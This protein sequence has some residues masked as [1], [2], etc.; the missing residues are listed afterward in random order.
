MSTHS[1][2]TNEDSGVNMT[3]TSQSVSCQSN[4]IDISNL[5]IVVL[6]EEKTRSSFMLDTNNLEV[7][8]AVSKSPEHI[9]IIKVHSNAYL[10]VFCFGLSF[11]FNRIY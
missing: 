11:F 1:V 9:N 10:M 2:S 7:I 5:E 4:I 3:E 6:S 8:E